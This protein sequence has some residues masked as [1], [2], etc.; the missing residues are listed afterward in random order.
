MKNVVLYNTSL[1]KGGTD[2]YMFELAINIDK[3]KFNVDI[4]IKDGDNVDSFL[5][6][7]LKKN[8]VNVFLAKGN[9]INRILAIRKFFKQNKNKYDVAHINATSEGTGLISYF[10][11]KVGKVKKVIF[12]SHMGGIDRNKGLVDKVG[13]KLMFKYSDVFASCSTEASQ[14]MFGKKFAEENKVVVLNNSVDISIFNFDETIR[15]NTRKLLNIDDNKFVLLHVGRFAPQKNHK[16]LIDVFAELKKVNSNAVLVLI[17]EGVLLEEVQQQVANLNLVEDIKFLGLKNNVSDYMQASDCF[18]MTSLHEGLP[19]VAVEAQACGLP[20][21]LSSNIS[22][23]TKLAENVE[24]VDLNS[25]LNEWINAILKFRDKER[26]SGEEILKEH[27]FDH[28]SAIEF[29]EKLYES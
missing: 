25:P 13:T 7:E 9:A 10:A 16:L 4:I 8:N 26:T 23:E 21:V 12:H 22:K 15:K 6:D 11:K 28:K 17:G 24:F 29:I 18:V 3:S 5:Y 14:F 2:K 1:L 20:C 19:I 27:K